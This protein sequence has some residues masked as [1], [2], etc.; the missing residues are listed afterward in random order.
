MRLFSLGEAVSLRHSVFFMNAR[1]RQ[2]LF[3][4]I[5]IGVGLFQLY[6]KD[7]SE[8]CLY[9]LAGLAFIVNTLTGE[10]K[11]AAYKKALVIITWLLIVST[12]IL[13]LYLI[14]FKYR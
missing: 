14:Q 10:P 9:S 6:I 4:L 3:G 5:F 11:L 13:F 12:A 7:Y 8:A 1:I 2:Y